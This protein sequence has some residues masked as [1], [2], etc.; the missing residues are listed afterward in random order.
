MTEAGLR[1]M[2]AA[3]DDLL[4]V[5]AAMTTAQ[6]ETES[7]AVGWTVK[8]I[9]IHIGSALE[10]VQAAVAGAEA[11]PLG[12]EELNDI[13][14]AE[15][16]HW[17][18][19]ATIDFL[20]DQ[21]ESATA[22]FAG[23]QAEPLAATPTPILDLGTYPLHAITDMFTFDMTTHLRYDILPPRGPIPIQVTNFD[24]VRLAPSVS[25]LA[26]GLEQMQPDLAAHVTAPIAL[27]LTG[28]GGRQLL[29]H[30]DKGAL[31]VTEA[32]DAGARAAA[33]IVSSTEDF[34]SWSTKR[35]PWSAITRIEGDHDLA[36]DFLD[37]VNLI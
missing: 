31:T 12:T 13:V 20:R 24:E 18:A 8:D 21:I 15:R 2:R 26:S 11:P 28:P 19:P 30:A 14:V 9:F 6:W 29:L 37:F 10:F 23:L 3:G 35:A 1:G 27:Q 33:T 5:A 25:W 7:A 17:T 36:A 16:R 4:Q 32:G 22:T 34:V